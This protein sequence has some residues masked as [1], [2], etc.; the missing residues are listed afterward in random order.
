MGNEKKTCADCLHC[1][2]SAKS[3]ETC[4]LCFCNLSKN[5]KTHKKTYWQTKPVCGKFDDMSEKVKGFFPVLT[6]KRR[7]LLR[8]RDYE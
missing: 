7:P 2:V 3:T 1:K 5:K 4:G 6:A 8:R